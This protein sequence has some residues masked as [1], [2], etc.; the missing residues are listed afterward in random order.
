[1]KTL[2]LSSSPNLR[3]NKVVKLTLSFTGPLTKRNLNFRISTF[4]RYMRRVNSLIPFSGY[5]YSR[6]YIC[7]IKHN[8]CNIGNR[9]KYYGCSKSVEFLCIFFR[10]HVILNNLKLGVYKLT[11]RIKLIIK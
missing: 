5:K 2:A 9:P 7:R 8:F 11:R 10:H 3:I 1:M 4:K 6:L